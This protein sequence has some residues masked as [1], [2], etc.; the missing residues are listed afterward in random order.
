VKPLTLIANVVFALAVI[1]TVVVL[2]WWEYDVMLDRRHTVL[3]TSPTPIYAGEGGGQVMCEGMGIVIAQP[4]ASF[5]V[6]RI[7]YWK[8]CATVDV[9]LQDGRIGHI[10]DFGAISITP[11]LDMH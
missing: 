1:A 9:K 5:R 6:K 8:D 10:A 4:G 2:C 11:P 7:R 3:V